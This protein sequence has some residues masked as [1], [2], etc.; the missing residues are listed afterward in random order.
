LL[1]IAGALVLWWLHVSLDRP[2]A[3]DWTAIFT[4]VLAI[5]TIG[6]WLVTLKSARIAERALTQLERPHLRFTPQGHT[7]KQFWSEI[8]REDSGAIRAN[9]EILFVFKNYGKYPAYMTN[10]HFS[11][12]IQTE[13]PALEGATLQPLEGDL[14][15]APD[16]ETV[17]H[18]AGAHGTYELHERQNMRA[19][20]I[21]LVGKLVYGNVVGIGNDFETEFLWR[22]NPETGNL[23]RFDGAGPDRNH[24]T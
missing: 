1:A 5:S 24:C 6:L 21:W 13:P 18:M 9:T 10:L 15:I 12:V 17:K 3:P 20:H 22:F 4:S 11:I 23:V 7:L 2:F 8:L 16:S 19:E 14:I